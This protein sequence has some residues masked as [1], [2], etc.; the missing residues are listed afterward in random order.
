[1][2]ESCNLR[3]C[4]R[5]ATWNDCVPE[6]RPLGAVSGSRDGELFNAYGG[7][8]RIYRGARPRGRARGRELPALSS[9]RLGRSYRIQQRRDYCRALCDDAAHRQ[10]YANALA[11]KMLVI[12]VSRRIVRR[13]GDDIVKWIDE[14]G[15]AGLATAK[16]LSGAHIVRSFN[17]IGFA[18]LPQHARPPVELVGVP[19][20]GNHPNLLCRIAFHSGDWPRTRRGRRRGDGQN[21][22][23]RERL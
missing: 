2:R 15:R 3:V 12:D 20:A 7:Q 9:S 16:L 8:D 18:K 10:S 13:D 22:W 1:M 17:A 11:K 4:G 21:I 5:S 23:S 6:Q 19:T 14:Q